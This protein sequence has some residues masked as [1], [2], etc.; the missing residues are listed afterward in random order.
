VFCWYV[1]RLS[2]LSLELYQFRVFNF[3]CNLWVVDVIVI[4]TLGSR[5]KSFGMRVFPLSG[6]INNS[7]LCIWLS[8]SGANLVLNMRFSHR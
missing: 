6:S 2:P 4:L 7:Y 1:I 3:G 8:L 5:R